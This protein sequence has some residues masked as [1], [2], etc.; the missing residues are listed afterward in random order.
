MTDS[1]PPIAVAGA[2]GYLG[3]AIARH[4]Q[5][6]GI[7]VTGVVRREAE[8]GGWVGDTVLVTGPSVDRDEWLRAITGHS[9]LV[10]A[11][12][13]AHQTSPAA[14]SL[15]WDGHVEI[16]REIGAAAARSSV[17][18]VIYVS[19]SKACGSGADSD[20]CGAP[21]DAYGF[22][23][24]AAE[25]LLKARAESGG[26]QLSIIRPSAVYGPDCHGNVA[27]LSRMVRA[28]VP[29]PV[30]GI[31][32]RRTF[33]YL[34][35]LV[36][37]VALLVSRGPTGQVGTYHLSDGVVLST[38]QLVTLLGEAMSRTPRVVP[39]IL[40]KFVV[41]QATRNAN[42]VRLWG[43]AVALPTEL[44]DQYGWRPPVGVLD[45]LSRSFGAPHLS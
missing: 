22:A 18:H 6:H 43:D 26:F 16:A 42:L 33:T 28:G 11:A 32:N 17:D 37:A 41:A 3:S 4:L 45:G 12:G 25:E 38:E 21:T 39:V 20:E 14:W 24:R 1:P 9:V 10:V 34:G 8:L 40:P 23:K 7:P 13:I 30:G 31:E 36:D 27:R 29:L 2:N 15:H 44:A 19:S 35:N 5:G